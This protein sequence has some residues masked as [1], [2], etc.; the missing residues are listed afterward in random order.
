MALLDLGLK[1]VDTGTVPGFVIIGDEADAGIAEL[2]SWMKGNLQPAREAKE[3]G[4]TGCY[5]VEFYPRRHFAFLFIDESGIPRLYNSSDIRI[6]D[7]EFAPALSGEVALKRMLELTN[8]NGDTP[9][10]KF[11]SVKVMGAEDAGVVEEKVIRF[12][13]VVDEGLEEIRREQE[14]EEAELRRVKEE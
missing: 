6:F 12:Y 7:E 4:E 11:S 3:A 2:D 13:N 8:R 9:W 10:N 1:N 14:I 5:I